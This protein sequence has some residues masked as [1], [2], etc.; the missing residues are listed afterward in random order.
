MVPDQLSAGKKK[1]QGAITAKDVLAGKGLDASTFHFPIAIAFYFKGM[2]DL[3]RWQGH[4]ARVELKVFGLE[5]VIGV[6][7]AGAFSEQLRIGD[8]LIADRAI[9]SDGASKAYTQ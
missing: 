9:V 2:A 3:P 7:A 4:S 6:G 1:V 5:Y 8:I